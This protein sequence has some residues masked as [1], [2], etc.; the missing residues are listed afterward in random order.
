MGW[1]VHC[2][3]LSFDSTEIVHT[4]LADP[5][6]VNRIHICEPGT[7]LAH[8]CRIQYETPDAGSKFVGGLVNL[9]LI[10]VI[11]IERLEVMAH[12]T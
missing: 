7:S 11:M 5:S 8:T 1:M 9:C 6:L 2:A 12:G 3:L 10:L 4:G